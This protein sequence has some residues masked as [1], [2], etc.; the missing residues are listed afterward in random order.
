MTDAS[1]VGLGVRLG[2]GEGVGLGD[3]FFFRLPLREGDG[4]F[5]GDD[6]ASGVELGVGVSFGVAA[7]VGDE[8]FFFEGKGVGEGLFFDVVDAFF[9]FGG[10]V[11]SKMRLIFVPNDSSARAAG[12]ARTRMIAS[13]TK[14]GPTP[15]RVI[16]SPRRRRGTSRSILGL[17]LEKAY[18]SILRE[19]PRRAS[20]ASE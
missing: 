20:P 10:G 8:S 11:G 5:L 14:R 15:Q 6:E 19:V 1:G 17:L 2:V 18:P 12:T 16:P 9:F 7:G 4:E 13:R 3:T